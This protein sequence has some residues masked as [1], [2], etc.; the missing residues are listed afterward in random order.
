MCA[1]TLIRT[2]ALNEFLRALPASFVGV[3]L[4]LS[5]CHAFG[6]PCSGA[7][8]HNGSRRGRARVPACQ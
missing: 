2:E 3:A 5:A 4:V 6:S 8:A 1:P 7:G